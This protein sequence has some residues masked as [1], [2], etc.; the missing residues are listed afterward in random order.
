MALAGTCSAWF[1]I[2]AFV[3]PPDK[4]PSPSPCLPLVLGPAVRTPPLLHLGLHNSLSE[5]GAGG[6]AAGSA[7]ITLF[8]PYWLNNRTGEAASWH[9]VHA[10]CRCCPSLLPLKAMQ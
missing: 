8:S 4:Q 10:S 1:L 5:R 3:P 9:C 2:L 7:R 6:A